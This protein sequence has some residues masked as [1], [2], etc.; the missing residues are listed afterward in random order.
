VADGDV[1][2]ERAQVVLVEHLRDEAHLF[3][4]CGAVAVGD[5]DAG[6]LLSPMLQGEQPKEGH[7]GHGHVS[8]KDPKDATGFG[9]AIQGFRMIEH[10]FASHVCPVTG[11]WQGPGPLR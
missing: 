5:G 2:L 4:Q 8:R 7:S 3:V 10:V 1:P 6:A 9:R 11:D